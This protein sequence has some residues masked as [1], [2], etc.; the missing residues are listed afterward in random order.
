MSDIAV[1]ILFYEKLQQTVDCIKS[2]AA[3]RAPVYVLSN[4][5]SCA[6]AQA[7]QKAVESWSNVR[8]RISQENLGVA[9]GRNKL[10]EIAEHDWLFFVDND[11]IV[12]Q[13][14]W[15]EICSDYMKKYDGNIDVF[16]PLLY[17]VHDRSYV[18][19][20]FFD[21]ESGRGCSVPPDL[22]I[23][24]MFPG[25]ASLIRRSKLDEL[26]GYA[27]DIFTGYEDFELAIRAVRAGCPIRAMEIPEVKLVHAHRPTQDELNHKAVEVRYA[28]EYLRHSQDYVQKKYGIR[29]APGENWSI[30]QKRHMIPHHTDAIS[31]QT[32][33]SPKE[34]ALYVSDRCNLACRGCRRQTVEKGSMPDMTLAVVKR[35]FALYPSIASVCVAGYGEP[36]MA[37]EFQNIMHFLEQRKVICSLITNGINADPL[38]RLNARPSYISISLYGTD[39]AS[40]KEYCGRAVFNDVMRTYA[41]LRRQK[42]RVGFSFILGKK[43]IGQLPAVLDLCDELHPDFLHLYPF[44]IY[45]MCDQDS[46]NNIITIEDRDNIKY[47]NMLTEGKE[48]VHKPL[49][50]DFFSTHYTCSSYARMIGVDAVGNISGCTRQIPPAQKY[51]NIFQEKDPFNNLEMCTLRQTALLHCVPHSEC[52]YCFGRYRDSEEFPEPTGDEINEV[53]Q[54]GLFDEV[55]YREHYL[56]GRAAIMPPIVHFL[57][58]GPRKGYWPNANFDPVWY[59]T[60]YPECVFSGLNPLLHYI[61]Y[62]AQLGYKP[63]AYFDV[64]K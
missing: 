54:S 8:I 23:T 9:C 18:Q 36:T 12:Q 44:L 40:Y 38:L 57:R 37:P 11:I 61:R 6:S 3:S 21:A 2:F 13:V 7:L 64:D 20:L 29:L 26:G 31:P 22:P 52:L 17:N 33:V 62:G 30:E 25:G 41:Q 5:S 50:P 16:T 32:K 47:I 53:L 59:R 55:W 15:R 43:S 10:I 1:C 28:P 49:F 51:G 27:T 58:F 4:G 19:R 48:Y 34:A 42:Q 45:N 35:L 24:N 56:L 14:K 63:S 60:Q 39:N 46:I